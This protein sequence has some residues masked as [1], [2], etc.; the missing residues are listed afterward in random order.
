MRPLYSTKPSL[1]KRF[2]NKLT[3]DRVVPI[4]TNFAH[5]TADKLNS[6]AD[7][8]RN[9]DV[10]RMIGDVETIVKDNPGPALLIAAALGFLVDRA[11]SRND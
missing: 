3:R 5:A 8:V 9:H 6:T 4:I 10:G 2:I 7:N 11:F 1:R